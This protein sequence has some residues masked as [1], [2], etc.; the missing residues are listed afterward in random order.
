MAYT[1]WK[2]L[3]TL[4]ATKS[5][6]NRLV[7]KQWLYTFRMNECEHLRGHINQYITLLNDL[8]NN[9]VQIDDEDQTMLLPL[10]YKSFRKILIYGKDNLL[11]K[12][13]KGHL[14]RKDKLDNEFGSNSKLD[15][16][17]WILVVSRKRDKRCRY[18]KGGVVHMRNGSP[19]KVISIGTVQIGINDRTIRIL[20]DVSY[21]PDL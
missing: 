12:D 4:Y 8:K 11:F 21:V 17:A 9:E 2:R 1:L 10:S 7:L 19:N 18:F 3:E 15:R 16:Q 14:L 13:V 20:S 5:L 6:A